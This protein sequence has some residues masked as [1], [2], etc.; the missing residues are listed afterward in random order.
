MSLIFSMTEGGWALELA[1]LSGIGAIALEG[2]IFIRCGWFLLFPTD[3]GP[4][5]S[6][7]KH[8]IVPIIALLGP[9]AALYGSV[10]P[11]VDF[12]T[13]CLRGLGLDYLGYHFD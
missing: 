10:L 13:R 1:F 2:S 12:S 9:A 6:V 4:Q 5:H 7:F 8:G 3:Y 11:Q